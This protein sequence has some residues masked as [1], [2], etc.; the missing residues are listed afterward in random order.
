MNSKKRILLVDD[1]RFIRS[2]VKL[3]LNEHDVVTLEDRVGVLE[4]IKEK[5][6]DVIVLDY[7]LEGGATGVEILRMIKKHDE[8][9]R[10]IMIT[11]KSDDKIIDEC[12]LRGADFCYYKD[13]NLNNYI[14]DIV[15][16]IN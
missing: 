11:G 12:I 7:M 5:R 16:N 1:D 10:V 3:R 8:S 2:L 15:N 4:S 14:S 13:E 6:P 9:L